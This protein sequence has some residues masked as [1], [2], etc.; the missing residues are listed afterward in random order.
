MPADETIE[1]DEEFRYN[2]DEDETFERTHIKADGK[3]TRL[4]VHTPCRIERVAIT[5]PNNHPA[6]VHVN[7]DEGETAVIDTLYISGANDNGIFVNERHAGTLKIRNF[8]C[9]DAVEDAIYASPPG[10]PTY[11]SGKA[12]PKGGGGGTVEIDGFVA[13]NCRDYGGRLGSEGSFIKNGLAM[14]CIHGF[15]NLYAT[16]KGA[17]FENCRA[18]DCENALKTADHDDRNVGNWPET[19]VTTLENFRYDECE[20]D[21][22]PKPTAAGAPDVRGRPMRVVGLSK[23]F[24]DGCPAS[25]V[26]ALGETAPPQPPD[27]AEYVSVQAVGDDGSDGVSYSLTT[28]DGRFWKSENASSSDELRA[29]GTAIDGTVWA[30]WFD[31]YLVS[32]DADV[33][34]ETDSDSLLVTVDGEPLDSSF[35]AA[36]KD[37]QPDPEEI[38]RRARELASQDRE[39]LLA[40]IERFVANYESPHPDRNGGREQ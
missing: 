28:A 26:E 15:A 31:D 25:P 16:G 1:V 24:P 36:L 11:K 40:A 17:H 32:P 20:R 4:N 10:N 5:D 7:L 6:P 9:V 34:V 27:D 8:V 35:V 22:L 19:V 2:L 18:I 38:E 13:F 3:H 29:D 37:G 14:G 23:E 12:N 30:P 21:I 33:N 39:Q